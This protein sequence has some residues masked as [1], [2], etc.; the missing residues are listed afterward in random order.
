M[1]EAKGDEVPETVR[2]FLSWDEAREMHMA[3]MAFGSHAH[4]HSVL[5]QLDHGQQR[6]ELSAS[7]AILKQQL[8][9][10]ADLLAYPVGH[11]SSFSVETQRIAQELGYRSAFSHY[12]GVNLRGKTYAYDVKRTKMVCQSWSRF[13]VQSDV[14]RSTRVYWP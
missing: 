8:G 1:E 14:C 10:Q 9:V 13:R 2:R 6:E 11:K 4:S 7:R 5:S 12:G 3:S